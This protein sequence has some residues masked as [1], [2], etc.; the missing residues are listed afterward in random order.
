MIDKAMRALVLLIAIMGLRQTRSLAKEPL[1][2]RA[3]AHIGDH[4]FYHGPGIDC[5]VLSPDGR[6]IASAAN[7]DYNANVTDKER[8]A[9]DPV[10]VVWDA[11]TGER[12]RELRVP[13]GIIWR[14]AF[15]PDGKR[16]AAAYSISYPKANVV[17]FDVETSKLLRQ[18]DEFPNEVIHLQFSADGNQ[19]RV[20]EECGSV[21]AW[22]AATGKKL[23]VWEPPSVAPLRKDEDK[24]RAVLGVLSP[25]GKVIVWETGTSPRVT[26]GLHVH[27]ADSAK[28]LYQKKLQPPYRAWKSFA[29][30]PDSRRFVTN[31][32]NEGQLSVW[33]TTTGKELMTLEIPKM[34]R[35]ALA[36][37]GQ[38]A[39][40]EE[41]GLRVRFW[42]LKT[43]KPSR[44]FCPGIAPLTC[45]IP[46][47]SQVFSADGKT[48][49]LA[50]G[51]TLRLFD[52]RTGEE[53]VVSGH[54]AP[55]TPRFSADGR[56][57]FTSCV[58]RRCSWNVSSPSKSALLTV[59]GRKSWDNPYLDHSTDDRLF[60][61]LSESR[62]RVRETATGR[63]L[64]ELEKDD[65]NVAFSQFSPD[66]TQVLL[67]KIKD[68]QALF[69]DLFRLYNTKTGKV[70]AEIEPV[71]HIVALVF[72]PNG[73]LI[74]WT[75]N[76]GTVYLHDAVTGKAIRTLRS[77]RPLPGTEF[78]SAILLFSPDSEYLIEG[79]PMLPMRAFQVSSGRE[80]LR[81]YANPEKTSK[82]SPLSCAAYSL[83]GRLLAVAEKESGAIRLLE[84]VSGK[85]RAEFVG[86][87]HGVRGLAFSPD[88]K[89][90]ASGGE[91]NVVFLWDVTGARTPAAAEKTPA[92]W[93]SDLASEDGQ[94]A[95]DAIAGLL[96]KP[97]ASVALLQQRLHPAEAIGEKHLTRLLADL[98]GD[99]FEKREAASREL[100]QL[101]EQAE[102]A[103][104]QALKDRPSLEMRRRLE[105]LL[106]KL[107]HRTLPPETLRIL[108]S[109]EI[110]EHLDT[111][112]ARR[113]LD[114]LTKGA[115][116]AR[117]TQEAKRALD[118]LAKRR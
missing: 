90:L 37:D 111:A 7:Y 67:C 25:D 106:D 35:F 104:R 24:E 27:D 74:A 79:R 108:R 99:A 21:S 10:I 56:T 53:R 117:Q 54:R 50:S 94:R 65:W 116:A 102:A 46:Q 39:A 112:E 9:Y 49:L 3:L 86:H 118:R 82:A 66:A 62:L 55:I 15:S 48:L 93:W 88:G 29:F 43:G 28:L 61:D 58:E 41:E 97:E 20:S 51:S 96:R 19:V 32:H 100:A 113:C 109:I 40:I 75:N 105:A 11:A 68:R 70:L 6:R 12:L 101:G 77:S 78:D 110:L 36:P 85:V 1:P 45:G 42:D 17:L 59:K 69:P 2:P 84:I 87:R 33:E 95:G 16:L 115:P 52:T 71:G 31:E 34:H 23:R 8:D 89:T 92:A 26:F 76:T 30:S 83:D 98:D 91:D 64:C 73:R 57:L 47:P 81:F 44:D 13:R 60:L 103:L 22:D 5:A 72:S 63:I 114:M 107:E 80:I 38:R 14:L 18:L 4:R